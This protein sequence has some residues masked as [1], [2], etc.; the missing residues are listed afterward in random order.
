MLAP[1]IGPETW[2]LAGQFTG[3]YNGGGVNFAA[4]GRAF[5]TSSELFSVAITADVLVTALWMMACLVMPVLFGRHKN[6]ELDTSLSN[7]DEG[8][9]HSKL[10]QALYTSQAPVTL[11]GIGLLVVVAVGAVW[12][13]QQ[14][15]TWIPFIPGILWLTT[16]ALVVAQ[17]PIIK[18]VPGAALLGYYLL[19]LFLATNGAQSV[20][21]KI[22]TAGP[23]VLYFALGTVALHGIFIFG[24]GWLLRMDPA[25][26][27]VASQANVGGPASAM[28]LATARGSTHLVLPGIAVG[29]LGYAIGN[30]TGFILGMMTR[31][32]LPGF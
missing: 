4:L 23:S 31:S 12:G 7:T 5:D 1:L 3:T 30:Y 6:T 29:L 21:M 25:T 15:G 19:L 24:F 13:A 26:L 10:I 17:L 20:V 11:R 8:A 2:K 22:L 9:K 14:L 18:R 27:A 32:L 28:A 16:I